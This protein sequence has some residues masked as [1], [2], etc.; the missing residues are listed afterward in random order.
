MKLETQHPGWEE[1]HAE[2]DK[3]NEI[4]TEKH[5]TFSFSLAILI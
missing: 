1:P 2:V 3:Y 4:I 5:I